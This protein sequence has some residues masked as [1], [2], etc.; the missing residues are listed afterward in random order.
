M[1]RLA[2]LLLS[3]PAAALGALAVGSLALASPAHAWWRGGVFVGI[4][5]P[6]LYFGPPVFFSPP[7][8][9]APPPVVYAPPG[10]GYAGP[11]AF[12]PPPAGFGQSCF[13]GA[14]MCPLPQSFPFG[15]ACSCP[16]NF[17]RRVF[18]QAR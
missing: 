4:A 16:D 5:P 3:R 8:V 9:Y 13:A 10:S 7:I 17:G 1:D 2:R 18:G 11:G 6:P 15:A 14:Y 12:P